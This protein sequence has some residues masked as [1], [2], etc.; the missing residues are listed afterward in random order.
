MLFYSELARTN[1]LMNMTKPY[2]IFVF[3]LAI[4]WSMWC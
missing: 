3:E 4:E 2:A 1:A